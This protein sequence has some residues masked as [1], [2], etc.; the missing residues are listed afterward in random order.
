MNLK[1][2]ILSYQNAQNFGAVL[3]AYGLQQTLKSLGYTDISFINYNP[4][5][6]R[7]RYLVFPSKWYLPKEKGIRMIVSFYI[8]LPFKLFNRWRRNSLFNNSR[9]RLLKQTS[10]IYNK[11]QDIHNIKCDALILG[12]DQIWSIWI[13]GVP[14]PVY[15]GK[16]DYIGLKRTISYAPSTEL[17]T[18][19]NPVVVNAISEYI[20][21]IDCLSVREE[22]VREKLKDIFGI[23]ARV[24]VDP[25]ILCGKEIFDRISSERM[26]H[27]EYILVYSY[28]NGAKPI[29]DVIK[30]I[31]EY[32]KYEIHYIS[33]GCSGVH[34]TFSRF[35][36][37]EIGVEEFVSLFKYASFVVTN[38]FHGLA[39]SL[40]YNTRFAVI[41]EEGKSARCES[42]LLQLGC[43]S[44]LIRSQDEV[45]WDSF[46]YEIINFKMEELRKQ[47]KD[48]LLNS[49]NGI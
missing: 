27:K 11:F 7:K 17:S 32:K 24:C 13:T 20:K 40:L 46:D 21:G 38:S 8:N 22:S 14:D 16:G 33:F 10:E 29:Q 39:F 48:F 15:F 42:L 4:N 5:Y 9:R 2:R 19:D 18:F 30:T 35:S 49:L 12:S 23:E 36:H 34:E 44:K 45:D 43:I 47:S 37:N 26:I 1:I 41:F 25:T 3:Q 31:P 6:L 28:D